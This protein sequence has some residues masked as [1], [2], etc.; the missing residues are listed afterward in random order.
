MTPESLSALAELRRGGHFEWYVVH[1][2]SFVI[3]V[4]ASAVRRREWDK[5]VLGLGFWAVEFLWEMG[6]ALVLHFTG[7]AALWTIAQKSVF[8]IYVGL[9]IEIALMFAVVPMVLFHLLPKERSLRIL[10]VPNRVFIPVAL[11][12]FCAGVECVLNRWGALVWSW[13][14][15]RYPHVWLIALAYCAPF[16]ALVW[17]HDHVSLRRKKAGAISAAVAAAGAHVLLANVLGWV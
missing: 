8:L 14:L 10:G 1:Q 3:Y 12:L 2:L 9:N 17:I 4:Y 13:Y 11:G 7:R 16:A 5:V 6:N 15:W